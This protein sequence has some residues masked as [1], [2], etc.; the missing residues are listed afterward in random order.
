M[1]L[2]SSEARDL[3]WRKA[4]RSAGNGAC[5]EVA[6][7]NGQIAV[8]DS[9][10]PG[11]S[12]QQYSV[13]SGKRS[14]RPLKSNIFSNK[15]VDGGRLLRLNP[16]PGTLKQP[17]SPLQALKA[18]GPEGDHD[19]SYRMWTVLYDLLHFVLN[20]SSECPILVRS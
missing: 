20:L 7:V 6:P 15:M 4:R 19:D 16:L 1:S 8:R 14:S 11:G 3:Q 18:L 12:R 2:S 10:N 9:M 5:V 17:A 13:R